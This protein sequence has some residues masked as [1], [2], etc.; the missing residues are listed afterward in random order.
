MNVIDETTHIIHICVGDGSF[1]M[2]FKSKESSLKQFA[3]IKDGIANEL[4]RVELADDFDSQIV[5]IP[6]K[7]SFIYTTPTSN[8]SNKGKLS[9]FN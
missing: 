2:S 3:I 1:V 9:T 4:R 6:A 5:V 8:P 7:I